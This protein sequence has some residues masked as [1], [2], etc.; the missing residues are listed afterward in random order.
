MKYYVRTFDEQGN[1]TKLYNKYS[2]EI[3][4]KVDENGYL[5]VPKGTFAENG[6]PFK[7]YTNAL[8]VE[9]YSCNICELNA[10]KATYIDC[11]RCDIYWLEADKVEILKCNKNPLNIIHAP[12]AVEIECENCSN[13][14]EITAPK[15]EKLS[16]SEC[17]FSYTIMQE[18]D[19]PL[20]KEL[21]IQDTNVTEIKFPNLKYLKTDTKLQ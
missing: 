17:Q 11:D 5:K 8:K 3:S 12:K 9:C 21:A 10:N 16:C 1:K 14:E 20:L 18:A 15:L 2:Q 7:L 19:F 13:I 6:Y 4:L